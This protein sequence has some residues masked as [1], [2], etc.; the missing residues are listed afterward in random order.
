MLT[1]LSSGLMGLFG[2]RFLITA[3]LPSLLYW[4]GFEG[5]LFDGS[6][7]LLCGGNGTLLTSPDG[8]NFTKRTT[9]TTAFLTSLT[10]YP[11][12]WMASGANGTLLTSTNT[13]NWTMKHMTTNWLSEVA[14]LNG[15]VIAVPSPADVRARR[16]PATGAI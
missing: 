14:Y 6:Q 1:S 16:V 7:F 8:V 9:G 10:L 12:G 4:G 15:I 13:I 5:V 2:R 3:W 11:G